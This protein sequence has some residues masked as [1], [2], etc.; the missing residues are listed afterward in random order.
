MP[1]LPLGGPSHA[2]AG[3][4]TH[5]VIPKTVTLGGCGGCHTG[6]A[7]GGGVPDRRVGPGTAARRFQAFA[8]PFYGVDG[9]GGCLG[10]VPRRPGRPVPYAETPGSPARSPGRPPWPGGRGGKGA[11]PWV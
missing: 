7:G 10:S 6:P 3:T 9:G 11:R 5:S 4:A 2:G 1:L 8:P